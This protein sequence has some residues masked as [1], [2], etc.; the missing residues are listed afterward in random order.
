MSSDSINLQSKLCV[1]I[2]ISLGSMEKMFG[3]LTL[4]SN[5]A[6]ST[7]L[8]VSFKSETLFSRNIESKVMRVSEQSSFER[9]F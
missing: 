8:N 4:I 2:K 6:F 5:N 1:S 9:G 7:A 3:S